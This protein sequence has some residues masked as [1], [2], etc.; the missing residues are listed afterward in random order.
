MGASIAGVAEKLLPAGEEFFLSWPRHVSVDIYPFSL[1]CPLLDLSLLVYLSPSPRCT[2]RL[3]GIILGR[4]KYQQSKPKAQMEFM[5]SL[6][7]VLLS[8]CNCRCLNRIKWNICPYSLSI[9]T[10]K[11]TQCLRSR[12][13]SNVFQTFHQM[14]N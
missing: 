8:S 5:P 7:N 10:G 2:A 6:S 1:S 3:L 4:A 12:P 11:C 9:A 13:T 14:S